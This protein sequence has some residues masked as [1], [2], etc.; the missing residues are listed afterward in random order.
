MI[1]VENVPLNAYSRPGKQGTKKDDEANARSYVI[2]DYDDSDDGL[3]DLE[4][5]DDEGK[6]I[7]TYNA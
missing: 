4:D 3:V 2:G 7:S 1:P 6:A 5:E